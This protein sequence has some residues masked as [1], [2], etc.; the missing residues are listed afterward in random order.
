MINIGQYAEDKINIWFEEHPEKRKILD[1]FVE[2][3]N[4]QDQS[5]G[6]II[7]RMPDK[8]REQF[9]DLFKEIIGM[10]KEI[11]KTMGLI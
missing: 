8:D 1:D 7:M 3:N 5:L 4:L 6:L 10:S 9:T 2:K 11:L